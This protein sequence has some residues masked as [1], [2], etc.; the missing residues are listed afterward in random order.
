MCIRD[1]YQRRVHG[2]RSVLQ[3]QRL[4][5]N[6]ELR[7]NMQNQRSRSPSAH[8]P[9]SF[10]TTD[11]EY[12]NKFGEPISP[13]FKPSSSPSD[14]P[15]ISLP[16]SKLLGSENQL[17]SSSAGCMSKRFSLSTLQGNLDMKN[18]DITDIE[19][20]EMPNEDD[21]EGN[22]KDMPEGATE[23][24]ESNLAP[25]SSYQKKTEST[26]LNLSRGRSQSETLSE[27]SIFS[28]MENRRRIRE[29]DINLQKR[30][31]QITFNAIKIDVVV[32][33]YRDFV[34]G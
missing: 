5:K 17:P 32:E 28:F 11:A 25:S 13:R 12:I 27:R 3:L 18:F 6:R 20:E 10:S 9:R 2:D 4:S 23:D 7:I 24:K 14:P 34:Y 33:A 8:R 21:A 29:R 26:G 22:L 1:R 31:R 30:N 15:T 16:E 19:I